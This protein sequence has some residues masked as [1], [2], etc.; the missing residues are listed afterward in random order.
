[1]RQCL[2]VCWLSALCTERLPSVWQGQC[3]SISSKSPW[4]DADAPGARMCLSLPILSSERHPTVNSARHL[5]DSKWRKMHG[6][7]YPCG[8]SCVYQTRQLL[9]I[10]P[11]G[12]QAHP[13][14]AVILCGQICSTWQFLMQCGPSARCSYCTC[15]RSKNFASGNS[16]TPTHFSVAHCYLRNSYWLDR[17]MD[18]TLLV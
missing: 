5:N 3:G 15:E 14:L 9:Q 16:R 10:E 17:Q 18:Q 2:Q 11:T 12:T 8:S 7:A 4:H 1:M 6:R 13:D